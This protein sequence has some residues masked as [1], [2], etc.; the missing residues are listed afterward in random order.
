MKFLE[1]RRGHTHHFVENKLNNLGELYLNDEIFGP[2]RP[3][4]RL[5]ELLDIKTVPGDPIKSPKSLSFSPPLYGK[6]A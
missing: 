2:I 5:R 1:K 4:P 6:R 3:Y